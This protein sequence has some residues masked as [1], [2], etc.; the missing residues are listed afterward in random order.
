MAQLFICNNFCQL[1][2]DIVD[3]SAFYTWFSTRSEQQRI[4]SPAVSFTRCRVPRDTWRSWRGFK[5][6]RI[7]VWRINIVCNSA[8][9][10]SHRL[11]LFNVA[12][13]VCV[14][15]DSAAVRTQATWSR[16]HGA[17]TGLAHRSLTPASCTSIQFFMQ[18][19]WRCLLVYC[20]WNTNCPVAIRCRMAVNV[21]SVG[22]L[23]LSKS[24][25]S[26]S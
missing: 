10:M 26:S 13:C 14:C 23:V 8:G 16:V 9:V 6:K 24:K 7:F 25:H 19:I 4:E 15:V 5:S 20:Y 21:K 1:V 17:D 22:V 3:N 18:T 2:I 12:R 11:T